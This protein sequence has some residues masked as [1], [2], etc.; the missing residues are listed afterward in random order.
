MRYFNEDTE[1]WIK[2][3]KME[4]FIKVKGEEDYNVTYFWSR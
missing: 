3:V 2:I 1:R 4:E